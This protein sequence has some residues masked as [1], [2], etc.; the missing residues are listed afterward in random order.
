MEC[1]IRDYLEIADERA[2]CRS[3][4]VCFEPVLETLE[5]LVGERALKQVMFKL[6]T[7]SLKLQTRVVGFPSALPAKMVAS[8]YPP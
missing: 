8:G 7:N 1:V 5:V 6:F 4:D 2:D 3:I